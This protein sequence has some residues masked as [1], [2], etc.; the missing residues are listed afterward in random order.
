MIGVWF[1]G[2]TEL[3]HEQIIEITFNLGMNVNSMTPIKL[4]AEFTCVLCICACDLALK[5]VKNVH[6]EA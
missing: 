5:G 3:S 1:K 2:K 6:R 4:T